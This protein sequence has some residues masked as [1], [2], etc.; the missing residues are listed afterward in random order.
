MRDSIDHIYRIVIVTVDR[1]TAGPIERVGPRL[2]ADFPGLEVSVHAS[3][4]WGEDP[5]ALETARA[6]V[7]EADIIVSGALFL[8]EHLSAILPQRRARRDACDAFVGIVSDPQIVSLTK[9]EWSS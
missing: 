1:H 9:I 8:E 5:A 7:L 6:A 3:A 4:E 2:A